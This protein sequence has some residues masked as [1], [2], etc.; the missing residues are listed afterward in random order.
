MFLLEA[1]TSFTQKLID[2]FNELLN[3][4]LSDSEC[5]EASLSLMKVLTHIADFCFTQYRNSNKTNKSL[6][7]NGQALIKRVIH[8]V[9][10]LKSMDLTDKVF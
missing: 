1:I 9:L 7:A 2:V 3:E 6:L 5:I 8:R 10:P 4:R